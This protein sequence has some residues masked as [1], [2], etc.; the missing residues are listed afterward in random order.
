MRS[1]DFCIV[2]I[3][4]APFNVWGEKCFLLCMFILFVFI[5]QVY[6]Y[7]MWIKNIS[8]YIFVSIKLK[9]SDFVDLPQIWNYT[10]FEKRELDYE[11]AHKATEKGG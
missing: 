11:C 10:C 3:D 4:L 1:L 9:L 7:Y 5:S 8:Q 6:N 2:D